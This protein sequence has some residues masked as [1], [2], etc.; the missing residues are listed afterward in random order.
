MI[1]KN[2]ETLY[3]LSYLPGTREFALNELRNERLQHE[4]VAEGKF[5]F[6]LSDKPALK[7]LCALR[8]FSNVHLCLSLPISRPKALLGHENFSRILQLFSKFNYR[9]FKGMRLEA[10]GRDSTIM[11]KIRNELSSN[12]GLN[13]D[14]EHGELQIIIRKSYYIT[15]W[16]FLVRCTN[17]PLSTRSWRKFN[18]R[19]ALDANLAACILQLLNLKDHQ[20]LCNLMCGSGTL[21]AETKYLAKRIELIGVEIS[22]S[23]LENSKIN[24]DG[25]N[26]TLHCEDACHTSLNSEKIDAVV[27]NLPWDEA[28]PSLAKDG[29]LLLRGKAIPDLYEEVLLETSR[30]LKCQGLACFI[31]QRIPQFEKALT[32]VSNLKLLSKH[33]VFQGGFHPSIF[34]LRKD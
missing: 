18:F 12:L 16:D 32:K 7:Q 20:T 31:T 28:I 25:L 9:H 21:L 17:R 3:E 19:G 22:Q 15:G 5:S 2:L 26:V 8:I 34:L 24:L 29:E 13:Y 1:K 10:A 33:K 14:Q 23:V 27:A 11:K 4:I 6:L 30:I